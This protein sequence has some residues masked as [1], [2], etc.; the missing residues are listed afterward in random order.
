MAAIIAAGSQQGRLTDDPM[1]DLLGGDLWR[2]VAGEELLPVKA[3]QG[4]EKSRAKV[5][6][7]NLLLSIR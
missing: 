5:E 4:E 6:A 2:L 3:S 7:Y 1:T